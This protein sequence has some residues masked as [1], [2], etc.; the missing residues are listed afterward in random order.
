M[1]NHVWVL[2]RRIRSL[3][4]LD[5][6]VSALRGFLHM[7]FVWDC[8]RHCCYHCCYSGKRI[9]SVDYRQLF[10]RFFQ[11]KKH[12]IPPTGWAYIVARG[13]EMIKQ[14]EKK[15]EKKVFSSVF[16]FLAH[17]DIQSNNFDTSRPI[18]LAFLAQFPFF[19]LTPILF[20]ICLYFNILRVAVP[21]LQ[22]PAL[23][24]CVTY[25]SEQPQALCIVVPWSPDVP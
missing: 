16:S 18:F 20:Y 21:L 10:K 19:T 14:Q 5:Q 23:P 2:I 15:E 1:A 9:I 25:W 7:H 17:S 22:C 11:K 24:R 4:K 8:N 6:H 13:R 3:I 12:H